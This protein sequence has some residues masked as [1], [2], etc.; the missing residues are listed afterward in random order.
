M[1]LEKLFESLVDARLPP[2]PAP[3]ERF[4]HIFRKTNADRDLLLRLRRT[5]ATDQLV[6]DLQIGGFEPF[7]REFGNFIIFLARD[8][9]RIDFFHVAARPQISAGV[10]NG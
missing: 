1:L 2:R 6:A 8:D 4:E 10:L 3:L 9:V 5:P 7:T